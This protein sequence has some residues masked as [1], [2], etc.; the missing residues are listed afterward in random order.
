MGDD[1]PNNA[2]LFITER[3]GFEDKQKLDQHG[4]VE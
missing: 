2:V 3:N 1:Q 4:I